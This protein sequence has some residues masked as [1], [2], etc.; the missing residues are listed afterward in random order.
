M[1]SC[2]GL[3]QDRL[4][5]RRR[6][7]PPFTEAGPDAPAARRCPGVC[8]CLADRC[9]RGARPR[10]GGQFGHPHPSLRQ[11]AWC[12]ARAANS[13]ASAG[14]TRPPHRSPSSPRWR[15]PT[16]GP[17]WCWARTAGSVRGARTAPASSVATIVARP[18]C[19]RSRHPWRGSIASSAAPRS[20]GGG[21]A[22]R[23]D[24][25]LHCWGPSG[26][27]DTDSF[28]VPTAMATLRLDPPRK[29]QVPA[30]MGGSRNQ[31]RVR[32]RRHGGVRRPWP[33][34]SAR[35]RPAAVQPPSALRS[36]GRCRRPG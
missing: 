11:T 30:S 2:P 36:A 27:K 32:R 5:R 25:T 20:C 23:E 26:S 8:N 7:T 28:R 4:D 33:R 1:A 9:S 22:L 21:A 35:P 16:P 17:A 14:W 19:G 12:F 15:W 31:I 10:P 6:S 13:T 24:G 34:T 18:A 29:P 3:C